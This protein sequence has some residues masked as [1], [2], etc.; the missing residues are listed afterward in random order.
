[1]RLNSLLIRPGSVSVDSA[2]L[3]FSSLC[4]CFFFPPFPIFSQ[5][6]ARSNGTEL[7]G[8]TLSYH[9]P[10]RRKKRVRDIS[11][12]SLPSPSWLNDIAFQNKAS[13]VLLFEGSR[14]NFFLLSSSF[15][16]LTRRRNKMLFST[17]K[18]LLAATVLAS[19]ALAAPTIPT[20]LVERSS[21]NDHHPISPKVMIISMVRPHSLVFYQK[22]LSLT[23]H[24]FAQFT[25]ERE[26]WLKPLGLTYNY[27]FAGS[28]PLFP[29]I[30][31][32]KNRSTCIVTT[33][34][35]QFL[36]FHSFISLSQWHSA[37]PGFLY[38]AEINAASTIMAMTLSSKFD[39]KK[40]YFLIAGIGGIRPS[41]GTLGSAAWARFSVQVS[42]LSR[43]Y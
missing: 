16:S 13:V 12:I 11:T 32:N 28:S 20:E 39:L 17:A 19:S 7:D 18:T 29:H 21:S 15:L 25:P 27:T 5:S 36:E 1:M 43:R 6:F 26:V 33:G 35:G 9:T 37:E 23:S 2:F 10:G 34:E 24:R 42:L 4:S 31:C 3:T 14:S 38:T 40:T 8:K 30:S 22:I 41:E